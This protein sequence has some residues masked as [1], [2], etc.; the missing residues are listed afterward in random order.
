[1]ITKNE[2]ISK[3]ERAL[4]LNANSMS[5][6]DCYY[7]CVNKEVLTDLLKHEHQIIFGRRG[8]GKTITFKAFTHYINAIQ[9]NT[10]LACWY[11]RLDNIIPNR[12]ELKNNTD[13]NEIIAIAIKKY[14][15][16]FLRFLYDK[17]A[18][19][20]NQ[21]SAGYNRDVFDE[22]RLEKI[23]ELMIKL[24][25]IIEEGTKKPE[26][27]SENEYSL[28]EKE[29]KGSIDV[30]ID[31]SKGFEKFW[32][33]ISFGLSKSKNKSKKIGIKREKAYIYQLDIDEIRDLLDEIVITMNMENIYICIDEFTQIDRD[34]SFSI[35]TQVAQIIKQLF[36]NSSV[37]VVKIASVWNES[38]MQ[39]RQVDGVRE[40]IELGQDIFYSN[41]LHF[42]TMF[43]HNN[44]FAFGFFSDMLL[45]LYLL[46]NEKEFNEKEKNALKDYIVNTLFSDRSFS[47][48]ICGSQGVSRVF[49]ILLLDCFDDLK[50]RGS[51]K[52]STRNVF[53]KVIQN[54]NIN[55]RKTIP[56]NLPICKAIDQFITDN[57]TR[58]FLIRA[59]E[60]DKAIN[61]FDGLVA[62]NAL[63][64][65]P[66]E[67][68]PRTI[69]NEYKMFYVH[70]GNY[71]E[72]LGDEGL[73]NLNR[74]EQ[75]DVLYPP[76]PNDIVSETD[77]YVLKLP[78]DTNSIY[79][80]TN[81]QS[82]HERQVDDHEFSVKCP[83][84]NVI[85][86]IW[87]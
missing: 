33:I 30:G 23:I 35:Q 83:R 21:Y 73:K 50:N 3:L 27:I 75:K 8:T 80:C 32:N 19:I 77:K 76:S 55:V 57:K 78:D 74:S 54:Y 38:R 42:D 82:Y 62:N 48:L 87:C 15:S 1:M 14:L 86:T 31:T 61:Y 56:Y 63:H 67:Q 81:C 64:Q 84:C 34:F 18:L 16:K 39:K 53:E 7:L 11:S 43:S 71:L 17:F 72:A 65:C 40:G 20:E 24:E 9:D 10:Y 49:G 69:K 41:C 60:Y 4:Q 45:N 5:F 25:E 79:Y 47:H 6:H 28:D 12:I 70:Y 58:F 52:V 37:F 68:L 44:D 46:H 2:L 59:Q 51:E 22:K 13:V 26:L 66:S 85:A 36:F 29:T